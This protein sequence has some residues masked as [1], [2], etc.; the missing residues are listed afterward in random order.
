VVSFIEETARRR[1]MI[2]KAMVHF[3]ALEGIIS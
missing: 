1:P 2:R 3:D